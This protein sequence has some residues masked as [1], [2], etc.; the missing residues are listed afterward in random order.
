[1]QRACRRNARFDDHRGHDHPWGWGWVA[2]MVHVS[3]KMTPRAEKRPLASQSAIFL[4]KIPRFGG[5]CVARCAPPP[6]RVQMAL[7]DIAPDGPRRPLEGPQDRSGAPLRHGTPLSHINILESVTFLC[8]TESMKPA[9]RPHRHVI[10]PGCGQIR[11]T[12]RK[13]SQYCR[14]ACRQAA[15]RRRHAARQAPT[16]K[17]DY[18]K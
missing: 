18:P 2:L 6:R 9:K 5:F 11:S 1:M 16:R 15:Y 4:G 13:N 17:N 8:Y 14:G 12:R 10:C 3:R 7:P